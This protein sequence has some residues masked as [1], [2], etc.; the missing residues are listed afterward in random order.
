MSDRLSH[1]C[2]IALIRLKKPFGQIARQ[3]GTPA[4]AVNKL[5]LLMEKQH[6]RGQDGAGVAA[7]KLDVPPGLPY[8][9]LDHSVK[10]DPIAA[11]YRRMGAAFRCEGEDRRDPESIRREAP[12]AAELLLG[13]L[14]YGTRG[15]N[16]AAACH[17]FF[18]RSNWMTRNLVLAGNFN[19]TN[20][21]ELFDRLIEFGQHPA[22]DT[23][24]NVVLEKFAHFLDCENDRLKQAY[25][26]RGIGPREA[27]DRLPDDLDIAG[28]LRGATK[29]FDGGYVLA[30]LLGHGAAFV[31]RDPHGIRPAYY[32]EGE[33]LAAVASERPALQSAF[34]VDES[35]VREIPPGHALIIARD[36]SLSEERIKTADAP[37]R[38]SFERIYFS[39]GSDGAIYRERKELGRR[40]TDAVLGAIDEDVENTV[41]SYIPNTSEIAF[42]GL[43]EGV[44]D[45][46]SD[47][48]ARLVETGGA[49]PEAIRRAVALR[50]RVDKIMNKDAKLRTFITND[51]DRRD[52]V[53][54]VYDATYVVVRPGAD[55]L[56]VVDD[57]IV[58]GTTLRTSILGILDRLRP[59]KIVV[60][61]SAPQIR[62]PDCYGIDMSKLA[63]F[64]AF[65]AMISL[66]R[67]RGMEEELRRVY[68]ACRASEAREEA[69]RSN[70]VQSLYALFTADEIS[71][72]IARILRPPD[73]RCE[74]TV[75]YQTIEDLH[76][77][78][79]DHAGDWYFTGNYPTPGGHRVA[80]RAFINFMEG[81]NERA[82]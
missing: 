19:M 62:Y 59:K 4:Y 74:L 54:M 44:Q 25:D 78:C 40:L 57:S 52:L 75:V 68:D 11:L 48:T 42:L 10:R 17:P 26:E 77:A 63:D 61:S 71:A 18:R 2:G 30:G 20:T 7:V 37:A 32:I 16:D 65:E 3:Y 45:W 64:V 60:A 27:M 29:H 80:H 6:N 79:P 1:E 38:C 36:G 22:D 73:L 69:P 81:R 53:S 33:D 43:M 28:M 14:R 50:P 15:R 70:H 34:G 23:D 8:I 66:V 24:T 46:L 58:R 5:Y 12:Y 9:A 35:A 21:P 41:F 51:R 31:L 47:R 72:E 56:V 67:Q 13:H 76:A 55:A 39:R 49:D 82:Y